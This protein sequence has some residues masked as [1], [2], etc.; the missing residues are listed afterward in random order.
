M[1][2]DGD[3][4]SGLL[5]GLV[6]RQDRGNFG[7]L[8]TQIEL[9]LGD[10]ATGG[11]FSVT[12]AD[13]EWVDELLREILEELASHTTAFPDSRQRFLVDALKG[14]Y[15]VAPYLRGSA[16]FG[17][18]ET[19]TEHAI[20]GESNPA[21]RTDVSRYAEVSID[22]LAQILSEWVK[23]NDTIA[24]Q[25]ANAA[26]GE[27]ARGVDAL[28]GAAQSIS[29]RIE[30]PLASEVVRSQRRAIEDHA[31]APLEGREEELRAVD[32][33]RGDRHHLGWR[34]IA[35]AGKSGLSYT[36]ANRGVEWGYVVPFFVSRY[37]ARANSRAAF[38]YVT[39]AYLAQLA[40]EPY[41]PAD[42]GGHDAET[43]WRELLRRAAYAARRDGRQVL[44]LVDALDEDVV[45]SGDQRVGS[46]AAL[47]PD[48]G[49]C[50]ALGVKIIIT[51]RPNPPLPPDVAADHWLRSPEVWTELEPSPVARDAIDPEEIHELMRDPV[52]KDIAGFL[53]VS[54]APL[55]IA[56]LGFLSEH[57]PAEISNV[58]ST[59]RSRNLVRERLE[60]GEEAFILGHQETHVEVVRGLEASVWDV[61]HLRDAPDWSLI[62]DDAL[63]PYAE[64]LMARATALMMR[65]W[66]HPSPY[67]LGAA[68]ISG[69]L[70]RGRLTDALNIVGDARRIQ[71]I[72]EREGSAY[73]AAAQISAVAGSWEVRSPA[74]LTSLARLLFA[75]NRYARPQLIVPDGTA[76]ALAS[77]GEVTRALRVA[78][79]V[80]NP[81]QR[82]RELEALGVVLCAVDEVSA[83]L[84][85][86]VEAA[87]AAGQGYGSQR[88]DALEDLAE[89]FAVRGELDR[90]LEC[91]RATDK[92]EAAHRALRRIGDSLV[93]RHEWK[94]VKSIQRR[95]PIIER[96]RMWLQA[97]VEGND[98]PGE[99]PGY[100]RDI[101]TKLARRIV[102]P[103]ARAELWCEIAQT[104]PDD[105]ARAAATTSAIRA[106]QAVSSD[107]GRADAWI[108]ISKVRFSAE[109]RAADL[110]RARLLT[111]GNTATPR[112]SDQLLTE[113]SRGYARDDDSR[114]AVC[115]SSIS[116]SKGRARA[117]AAIAA[118][119]AD[120]GAF[121]MAESEITHI[122]IGR[123][124][125]EAWASVAEAFAHNG[126]DANAWRSTERIVRQSTKDTLLMSFASRFAERG[127]LVNMNRA[128]DGI[129]GDADLRA[130]ALMIR[131]RVHGLGGNASAALR[132]LNDAR[133]SQSSSW[134]PSPGVLPSLVRIGKAD[135]AI[136]LVTEFA[137][138][139]ARD[140]SLATIAIACA[141]DGDTALAHAA[142]KSCRSHSALGAGWTSIAL[143]HARAGRIDSAKDAVS[144]AT[145]SA[146]GK[147]WAEIAASHARSQDLVAA[148]R[149]AA[150]IEP[151]PRKADVWTALALVSATAGSASD[152]LDAIDKITSG[153]RRARA[154]A[155]CAAVFEETDAQD[156]RAVSALISAEDEAH[157][158]SLP[159]TRAEVWRDIAARY[160][161][162]AE[163]RRATQ[164]LEE[165][166][167][168]ASSVSEPSVLSVHWIESAVVQHALG[169]V[170]ECAESTREAERSIHGIPEPLIRADAWS[171][172]A[173][174]HHRAGRPSDA[175]VALQTAWL[176]MNDPTVGWDVFEKIAPADAAELLESWVAAGSAATKAGGA[177]RV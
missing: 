36:I 155:A 52:G 154:L 84:D 31:P 43:T 95:L 110:E 91:V 81:I 55:T 119:H 98:P 32:S 42:P 160:V 85:V 128:V 149:I 39:G 118:D 67:F 37:D 94:G 145:P 48:A 153:P 134:W 40:G 2:L 1:I 109:E 72:V 138:S 20:G 57:M 87:E 19:H 124:R 108:A 107:V 27:L 133:A 105:G 15:A 129:K 97:S 115:I 6:D 13:R 123:A 144:R 79:G 82:A 140:S 66:R 104:A 58:L 25:V 5:G 162:I 158:I 54:G 174:F 143:A 170:A 70:D 68:F 61:P 112:R 23:A 64:R 173:D 113:I 26:L 159:E 150:W 35:K 24:P 71:V 46:I 47:L 130:R 8:L 80:P 96:A 7:Q 103:R 157:R 122:T 12:A 3:V 9:R 60:S 4:A 21:A 99:G 28:T 14:A 50:Q 127:S 131:S 90:A 78:R 75:Y 11:E 89:K 165:A 17:R 168:A 44:L 164:A 10:H 106:A 45:L 132:D 161:A 100:G 156:G 147:V 167:V 73:S 69:L 126:D 101:A 136:G 38:T 86:F 63:A 49:E 166:R 151:W 41:G 56:D 83:G 116:T 146:R 139:R 102:G 30:R 163:L 121:D 169:A 18:A 142:L 51:A 22:L 88:N 120:R 125:D 111:Q 172:L 135:R 114:A 93:R 29:A 141:D 148:K 76:A 137:D 92:D 171:R 77:V 34:G 16:A 117:W 176:T 152:A 62:R 59:Q 33:L 175:S 65:E 177:K 53:A 74:D